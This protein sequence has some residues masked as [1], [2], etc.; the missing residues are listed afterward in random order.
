MS[1]IPPSLAFLFDIGENPWAALPLV[2]SAP[3]SPPLQETLIAFSDLVIEHY[4]ELF[5][6]NGP[7]NLVATY[8]S[9][10]NPIDIQNDGLIWNQNDIFA[11]IGGVFGNDEI[12]VVSNNGRITVVTKFSLARGVA[13]SA[14]GIL[15]NQGSIFAISNHNQAVG[16]NP[17]FGGDLPSANSG[18]IE[19]WSGYADA[20]AVKADLG[21]EFVN[22]GTLSAKG[23]AA[24]FGLF[25]SGGI[26]LHNSG[27]IGAIAGTGGRSVAVHQ[28]WSGPLNVTNSGVIRADVAIEARLQYHAFQFITNMSNGV[29]QGD[30][31]LAKS[32]D[33]VTN[34]GLVVGNVSLG[35]FNDT[36]DS[37]DGRLV[38][39]L[40]LG[41]GDDTALGGV[42]ADSYFAGRGNDQMI[43][44]QGS[45]T[46][47][48]G[49]D[50]DS[51]FGDAQRDQVFGD[52]GDDVIDAGT[53]DDAAD[54]G[55]G[56]DRAFG[57]SGF[58]LLNGGGGNDTL[59]GGTDA[60]TLSGGNN[61]DVLEGGD[62]NDVLDGGDLNDVIFGN[63]GNDTIIFRKTGDTDTIRDFAAGAGAGDVI[64]LVGFGSGFDSFAEVLAAATDNGV[65]TTITFGGGDVIILRN[66]L[67]SQLAADDFTFG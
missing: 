15:Q 64:R 61:Y 65:D 2:G 58:D 27:T 50:N 33:S 22:S 30:I 23:Y 45:D 16:Y 38:G 57:G 4:E 62:G 19:A 17:Y 34:E 63:S 40:Y 12:G 51:L 1:A 18:V 55:T 67:A 53:G 42:W 48:G 60:D 6:H 7:S 59:Q 43:G 28:E 46:L 5:A 52:E 10:A 35:N 14:Q 32:T 20:Y 36:Y 47:R 11:P 66:V 25:A 44:G 29:I 41:D 9:F 54:G 56:R 37:T 26:T 21:I 49:D 31:T 3:T 8:D 24:A 13:T 39:A